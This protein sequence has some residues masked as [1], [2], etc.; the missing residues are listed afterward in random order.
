MVGWRGPATA[1]QTCV[2]TTPTDVRYAA[3]G[4]TAS[5]ATAPSDGASTT[6]GASAAAA[7]ASAGRCAT[8]S[9]APVVAGK[10]DPCL[11]EVPDGARVT[12]VTR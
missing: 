12:V 3:T 8:R 4:P 7:S 1:A 6:V 2:H 5:Q 10:A 9:P 11:A